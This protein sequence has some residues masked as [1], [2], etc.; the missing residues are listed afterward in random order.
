[1]KRLFRFL[2]LLAALAN[3]IAIIGRLFDLLIRT[4]W[5]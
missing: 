4:G 3:L 5:I 2:Q 1:M